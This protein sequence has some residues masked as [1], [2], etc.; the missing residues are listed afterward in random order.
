MTA[1]TLHVFLSIPENKRPT[2]RK[3]TGLTGASGKPLSHYGT[4]IFTL[5][6]GTVELQREI[7]VADI[8]DEGLLGHDVLLDGNA[9]IQYGDGIL[10]FRGISIPCI[11]VGGSQTA[12]KVRSADHFIIPSRSEAVIDVFV[13]GNDTGECHRHGGV[14]SASVRL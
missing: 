7:V 1:D 14:S 9:S 5:N 8:E 3:S 10:N 12:R 11:Q 2:L 13:E 6:L 4:A